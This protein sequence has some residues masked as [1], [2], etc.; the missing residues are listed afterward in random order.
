ML[1]NK[2]HN[3][4]EELGE[5]KRQ[6]SRLQGEGWDIKAAEQ[7][8]KQPC[9]NLGNWPLATSGWAGVAG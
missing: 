5:G 6:L 7:K 2:N 4:I 8:A 1:Q 9:T 3:L